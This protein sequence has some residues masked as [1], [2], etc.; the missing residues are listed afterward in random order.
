ME[1]TGG[2][3]GEGLGEG[4][5]SGCEEEEEKKEVRSGE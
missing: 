3:V 1:L 5:E 2:E 4:G